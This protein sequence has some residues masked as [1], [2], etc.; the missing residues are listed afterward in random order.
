LISAANDF[1]ADDNFGNCHDGL[2][3]QFNEGYSIEWSETGGGVSFMTENDE[4]VLGV[5]G[6][7][8]G[9]DGAI[10]T[11]ENGVCTVAGYWQ[12]VPEPG[13]LILLATGL[14]GLGLIRGR[15]LKHRV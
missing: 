15:R 6:G 12:E 1:G 8:I 2:C 10:G 4:A 14:L 11:C 5:T 7:T 13:S 9:S 3:S